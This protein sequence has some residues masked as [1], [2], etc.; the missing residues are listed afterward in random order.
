M[1]SKKASSGV[2]SRTRPPRL[3][4]MDTVN[5]PIKSVEIAKSNYWIFEH[6]A[7]DAYGYY[8][9][10]CPS[11]NCPKPVFSQNPLC[12]GRAEEHLRKCGHEFRD[13][14]DMV[15]RYAQPVSYHKKGQVS[16]K[17]ARR[18][19]SNL[20]ASDETHLERENIQKKGGTRRKTDRDC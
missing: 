16:E 9:M 10:R 1:R 18:H 12:K 6:Q 13:V 3:R 20:L 4:P 2:A 17:W 15:R 7:N 5:G 8:V 11:K 14:E 19:N